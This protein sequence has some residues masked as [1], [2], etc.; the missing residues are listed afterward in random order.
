MMRGDDQQGRALLEGAKLTAVEILQ[1]LPLN[2]KGSLDTK[3]LMNWE[4]LA[5]GGLR[6]ALKTCLVLG[7]VFDAGVHLP[8]GVSA[9]RMLLANKITM[10]N[11]W[12]YPQ[13][14]MSDT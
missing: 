3:S 7:L 6:S 2:E 5:G 10:I 1:I 8:L 14:I 11:L 13:V 12:P 4:L 9:C